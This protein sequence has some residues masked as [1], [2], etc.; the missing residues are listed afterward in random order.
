[1]LTALKKYFRFDHHQTNFRREIIGGITTFFTMSYIIIV[2]PKIL[3]AA[4]IPFGP[5]MVATILAAFF[6]TVAMGI[7]ARRPFA[8]APYMGEN[9]FIAFTVCGVLGYSWQT[10]L[11]A[12]FIGGV[13]FT[14]VSA[15][16]IRSWLAAAIP[17]SL[18]IAFA[19]GIGLFLTFIGLNETGI[20]TLG[21]PGAP[22][23][24]GELGSTPVILAV[25]CFLL[26]SV[27]MIRKVTGSL[28]IGILVTTVLAFVLKAAETPDEFISLPPSLEP[29]LFK[30]DIAG[31]F[32]WGFFSVILTVF[33]MDFVDTTG[34]LLGLSF[35]A[36]LLDENGNLPE[37]E[38]P[39]MCDSTA[40]VVGALLGTTTT[41]TFIE[42]AAGMEAGGRTGFTS[43]VT[44][45][46]FLLGLFLAP[47][48][49]A[50]PPC[51]YGPALIVVGLLMM[52]TITRLDFTD[53]TEA[54][55]AFCVI[56]LMSFTYNLGIGITAG[57]VVFP[58]MKIFAGKVREVNAGMWI[59]AVLS[60]LFFIFYPY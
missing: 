42:S 10:A 56:V 23:H 2:N 35:K 21:V 14:L 16:K 19:V 50:V 3:E 6:G 45:F 37:I 40:T 51:A 53:L 27:L 18:K 48:L 8:I 7:Y 58:I 15:L 59:L 34:T 28:L 29:I 32:T 9:A 54:I 25:V 46:L 44:A 12:I 20:V 1:M 30:L 4:G 36:G 13:L 57:F 17:N 49:T 52:T 47:F 60:L 38:K 24:V 26:I 33:V 43:I 55:P 5:S 22:V 11:G 31:A 39:M 41:G